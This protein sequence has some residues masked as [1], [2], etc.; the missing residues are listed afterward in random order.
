MSMVTINFLNWN[1]IRT[2]FFRSFLFA[3][4]LGLLATRPVHAAEKISDQALA[5]ILQQIDQRGNT[6]VIVELTS[7]D[8]RTTLAGQIADDIRKASVAR[9]QETLYSTLSLEDQQNI[10]HKYEYIPGIAMR[11][12]TESLERM[13]HNQFIKMVNASHLLVKVQNWFFQTRQL[14]DIP[15]IMN[16][17]SPYSIQESTRTT[18]SLKQG[19]PKRSSLRHAIHVAASQVATLK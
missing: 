13:K 19:Q 7:P 8:L 17:L 15:E 5:S 12:D 2:I 9:I 3:L 10:A 14:L 6:T 18:P 1:I 11:V 16:G 4:A